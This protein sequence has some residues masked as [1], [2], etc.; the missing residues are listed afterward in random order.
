MLPPKK[1]SKQLC[2]LDT[3][4]EYM[5]YYCDPIEGA[6]RRRTAVRIRG[7]DWIG[8]FALIFAALLIWSTVAAWDVS[9][10]AANRAG[11]SATIGAFGAAALMFSIDRNIKL[12]RVG[13]TAFFIGVAA[14]MYVMYTDIVIPDIRSKTG[15]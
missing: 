3:R 12:Q 1:L 2:T 7:Y 9:V 10:Q 8:L 6:Q 11:I 14:F 13:Q 4:R 5:L 15:W